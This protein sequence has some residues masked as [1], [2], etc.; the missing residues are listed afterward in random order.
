VRYMD[1]R[2]GIM[3]EPL[4]SKVS[5]GFRGALTAENLCPEHLGPHNRDYR[6]KV[7]PTRRPRAP[8]RANE[9]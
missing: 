9:M 1:R 7:T 6:I 4:L 2:L 5:Q 3:S 8:D